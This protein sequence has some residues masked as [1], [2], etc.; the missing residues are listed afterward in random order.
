MADDMKKYGVETVMSH[1]N[2]P[3]FDSTMV[4]VV[5][6]PEHY[7]DWMARLGSTYLESR[8]LQDVQRGADSNVHGLHPLPGLARGTEFGKSKKDSFTF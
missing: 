2:Q 1:A 5:K 3:G 4:S 8:L 7:D 6:V